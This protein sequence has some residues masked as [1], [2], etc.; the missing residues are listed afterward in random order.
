MAWN[1]RGQ[2]SDITTGC[3]D[4]EHARAI[5]NTTAGV[6]QLGTA[7]PSPVRPLAMLLLLPRITIAHTTRKAVVVLSPSCI[8]AGFSIR[9]TACSLHSLAPRTLAISFC[10]EVAFVMISFRIC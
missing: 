4:D 9:Y 10:L 1:R 7:E 2:I 3:N 6:T 8:D 5:P